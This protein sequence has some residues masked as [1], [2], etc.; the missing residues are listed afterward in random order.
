MRSIRKSIAWT[1]AIA[2][3]TSC[4]GNTVCQTVMSVT[5]PAEGTGAAPTDPRLQHRAM[6]IQVS[7]VIVSP[8]LSE[9]ARN[10]TAQGKD[11][12]A[13]SMFTFAPIG[14]MIFARDEET[15]PVSTTHAI[16][17]GRVTAY[18]D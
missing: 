12:A 8:I 16:E 13:P 18:D 17:T 3:G 15:R 7:T 5:I 1:Y 14:R 6:L 11:I 2:S 9:F 4:D 10:K